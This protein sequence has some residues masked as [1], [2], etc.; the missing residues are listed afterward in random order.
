M[1]CPYAR[2]DL[3]AYIDGEADPATREQI[4]KHLQVCP[5]C[6]REVAWLSTVA[7]MVRGLPRTEP[8][9][10]AAWDADRLAQRAPKPLHCTVVLPAASAY[11]DGELPDD[12][13]AAVVSHLAACDACYGVFKDLERTTEIL[14]ETQPVP[15]PEGLQDRVLAAV[16]ADNRAP[17]RL[18]RGVCVVGQCAAPG[19]RCTAR[20]AA[21]AAFVL[22]L[23]YAV[24]YAVTPNATLPS[25]RAPSPVAVAPQPA[26]QPSQPTV[27]AIELPPPADEPE[28]APAGLP[29]RPEDIT[30]AVAAVTSS[31]GPGPGP[32]PTASP[33]SPTAAPPS[34]VTGAPTVVAPPVVAAPAVP[35]PRS[36]GLAPSPPSMPVLT[37]P[38]GRPSEPAEP[39]RRPATSVPDVRL[40]DR[41]PSEAP[42]EPP[43][44]PAGPT[45]VAELPPTES[46]PAP[47]EVEVLAPRNTGWTAVYRPARGMDRESLDAAARRIG[48]A[49]EAD[50]RA[51]EPEFTIHP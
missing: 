21:A 9:R 46:S 19:L 34:E 11:L 48:A 25:P 23:G 41:T 43:P 30:S 16:E 35:A 50:K 1:S 47:E 20:L 38:V 7:Q 22:A 33:P 13:A 37:H 4:R 8:R 3:S 45:R 2:D 24:W 15:A 36:P 14:S 10:T 39:K 29:V 12:E 27:A 28:P 51:H 31:G 40:A 18:V 32:T 17:S 44:S 49:L 26:T 42:A 5:D 6:R